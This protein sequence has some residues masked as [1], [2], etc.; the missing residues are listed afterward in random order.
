[1]RVATRAIGRTAVDG[2][3]APLCD[4][5]GGGRATAA[6][7]LPRD[8]MVIGPD[9]TA[10]VGLIGADAYALLGEE[11]YRTVSLDAARALART[12]RVTGGW[13]GL[14]NGEG[15]TRLAYRRSEPAGGRDDGSDL[16]GAVTVDGLR[17]LLTVADQ[18]GDAEILAAA[19]YGLRAML[20]AQ[21]ADGGWPAAL[22][23]PDGDGR[24]ACLAEQVTPG[25]L[26]LLL[27]RPGPGCRAAAR[28]AWELLLQTVGA[29]GWPATLKPGAAADPAVAAP[30]A[31]ALLVLAEATGEPAWLAPL[32]RLGDALADH[33]ELRARLAAG[34]RAPAAE[35]SRTERAR[36]T[37]A[38][39]PGVA[40]WVGALD[41]RGHW[42]VDGRVSV[43][44]YVAAMNELLVYLRDYEPLP[45]FPGNQGGRPP[46]HRR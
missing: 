35:R 17:V 34:L 1:M 27:A 13:P 8:A 16:R 36:L 6:G 41:G 37:A 7:S 45:D 14:V 15:Y 3:Y 21:L 31:E 43:A 2:G 40:E 28:R 42:L 23:L 22:P 12:Q 25:L 19:E 30:V 4:P 38:R 44:R 26:Q 29:D 32:A 18:T 10:A 33:P 9:G 11:V 24:F 39:A 46:Q 20:N 5:D